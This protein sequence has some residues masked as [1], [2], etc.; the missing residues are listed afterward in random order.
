LD[1]LRPLNTDTGLEEAF[2]RLFDGLDVLPLVL[3]GDYERLQEERPL[4]ATELLV[5]ISWGRWHSLLAAK[6]V[7]TSPGE[8]P[9]VV[10]GS[11]SE[12]LGLQFPESP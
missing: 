4:E 3:R 8:W 10:D 11:Y 6:R 7:L 9:P 2:N 12:E 5:P 1:N